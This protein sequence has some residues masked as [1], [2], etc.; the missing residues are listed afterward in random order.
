MPK[1]ELG[2]FFKAKSVGA[3]VSKEEPSVATLNFCLLNG[4]FLSVSVPRHALKRLPS[5]IELVLKQTPLPAHART[6]R[7]AN[8]QSK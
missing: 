2:R 1:H 8:P 4:E 5:R 7:R 3:D 6:R